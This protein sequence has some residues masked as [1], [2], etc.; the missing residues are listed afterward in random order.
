M[1]AAQG[2]ERDRIKAEILAKLTPRMMPGSEPYTDAEL[3]R[4][5]KLISEA[6]AGDPGEHYEAAALELFNGPK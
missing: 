6:A 4:L 5:Y 2:Q 3:T 1:N